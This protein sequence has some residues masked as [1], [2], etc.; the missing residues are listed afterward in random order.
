MQSNPDEIISFQFCKICR[1]KFPKMS[2]RNLDSYVCVCERNMTNPYKY[3]RD[4]IETGVKFCI[5]TG[6]RKN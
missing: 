3:P 2:Q 1:V 6:E 4:L 5:G